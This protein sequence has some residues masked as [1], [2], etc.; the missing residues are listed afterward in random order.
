M[1][2]VARNIASVPESDDLI[3]ETGL[4]EEAMVEARQQFA[5]DNTVNSMVGPERKSPQRARHFCQLPREW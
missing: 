1:N 3:H 5:R 2:Q 4:M